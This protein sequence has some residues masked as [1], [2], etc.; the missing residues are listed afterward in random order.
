MKAA[1]NDAS[2][3]ASRPSLFLASTLL[4]SIPFHVWSVLWPVERLLSACRSR[5]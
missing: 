5:L 1:M 3:A 4:L 2:A